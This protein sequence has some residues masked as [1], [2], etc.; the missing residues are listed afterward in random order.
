M[1]QCLKFILS[2]VTN[3]NVSDGSSVHRQD[4]KTVHTATGICLLA[5]TSSSSFPLASSR[6]YLF[7]K[8]LLL[9]VE[10]L[11]PDDGRK[12]RPKHVELPL[13]IK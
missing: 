11:T 5:G 1:H 4:L 6:Q 13:Q 3:L 10:S 9:Y 8:C 7:D 2:A 12:N